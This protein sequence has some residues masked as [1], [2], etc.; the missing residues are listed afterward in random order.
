MIEISGEIE[1]TK[2][3]AECILERWLKAPVTCYTLKRLEGGMLNS[4]VKLEFNK[5][6]FC[7]VLKMNT[8]DS[9]DFPGEKKRLDYLKSINAL[10]VPEVY[11]IS[12]P[13]DDIPFCYLLMECV[14]GVNLSNPNLSIGERISIDK[15][16]AELLLKLHS[17]KRS[18]YGKIDDLKG[19]SNWLDIFVPKLIHI[20]NQTKNMLPSDL[21]INIKKIIEII[22]EVFCNLGKPTLVHGDIWD[23]NIIVDKIDNKWTVTGF[24]DP[25]IIYADVEYELAY[26][27]SF[28]KSNDVLFSVY[29]SVSPMREGYELRRL[30]YWLH[31]YL[32]HVW[33]FK[34]ENYK[35]LTEKTI[36]VILGKV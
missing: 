4:V 7:A 13:N 32:V 24:V 30:F 27:Q 22:P 16:I 15:E 33:Y 2:K 19:C 12:L 25:E 9:S 21:L 36:Y 34:T 35:N 1:I 31:T 6:P 14:S 8:N 26:L 29:N 28:T 18:S 17:H 3:Q 5:A 20:S 10:P 11:D 23:A